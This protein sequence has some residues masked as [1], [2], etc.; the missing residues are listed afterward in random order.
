MFTLSLIASVIGAL[1]LHVFNVSFHHWIHS[2]NEHFHVFVRRSIVM[3]LQNFSILIILVAYF[4]FELLVFWVLLKMIFQVPISYETLVTSWLFTQERSLAS[5][6]P[7][8]CFEVPLFSKPFVT[9][10]AYKRLLAIM[11]VYMNLQSPCSLVLL[12]ANFASIRLFPGVDHLMRFKMAI[13][14]K[15]FVASLKRTHARS[16]AGMRTHMYF[17][18]SYLLHIF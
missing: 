8:M 14:D 15:F 18:I 10:F 16:I 12:S 13:G 7:R 4:A 17:K 2:L 6:N 3:F 5:V 11:S 1:S 9:Y